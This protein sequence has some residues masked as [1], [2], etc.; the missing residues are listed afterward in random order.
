MSELSTSVSSNK[1]V[2]T[3]IYSDKSNPLIEQLFNKIQ[4]LIDNQNLY[5]SQQYINLISLFNPLSTIEKLRLYFYSFEISKFF[6]MKF[7][8]K[9]P[10]SKNKEEAS[11]FIS[12]NNLKTN[13]YLIKLFFCIKKITKYF[14]KYFDDIKTNIKHIILTKIYQFCSILHKE[15]EYLIEYYFI[16]EISDNEKYNKIMESNLRSEIFRRKN[17]LYNVLN[18]EIIQQRKKYTTNTFSTEYET[19]RRNFLDEKYNIVSKDLKEG[20]N[21]YII[22]TYWIK[23]FIYYINIISKES[24]NEEND[25]ELGQLLF[26]FSKTFYLYYKPNLSNDIFFNMPQH[27]LVHLIIFIFQ[28]I[29]IFGLTLKKKKNILTNFYQIKSLK[30]MIIKLLMKIYIIYYLKCLGLQCRK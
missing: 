30:I 14:L 7:S 8:P 15:K 1:K 11:S 12:S 28:E 16:S 13:I 24:N 26:Q 21:C 2:A 23:N 9:K 17:I 19:L 22:S 25:I 29:V 4:N 27:I 6:Y 20:D 5:E 3:V 10:K 18:K